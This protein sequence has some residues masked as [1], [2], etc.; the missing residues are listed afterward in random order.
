M[1]TVRATQ[2]A[3]RLTALQWL[4]VIIAAIGFAFDSYEL[5]MLPLIA[6]PA[7]AEL[8]HVQQLGER[9]RTARSSTTGPVSSSI[10]PRSPAASSACSADT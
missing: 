2:G 3:E 8:R 9:R 6:R 1:S 10:F 5:L 7:L 4:I